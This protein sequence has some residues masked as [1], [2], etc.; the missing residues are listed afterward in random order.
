[1][2]G[3]SPIATLSFFIFYKKDSFEKTTFIL[4]LIT[5]QFVMSYKL[6][7]LQ[8]TFF[9]TLSNATRRIH[10]L[11]MILKTALIS[12]R[13]NEDVSPPYIITLQITRHFYFAPFVMILFC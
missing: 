2:K 8:L 11:I 13:F 1:V 4:P 7:S 3:I 9:Q 10:D 12:E 5:N 6:K